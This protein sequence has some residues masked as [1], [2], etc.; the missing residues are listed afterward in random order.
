MKKLLFS[1]ALGAFCLVQADMTAQTLQKNNT[2]TS[3]TTKKVEK[4]DMVKKQSPKQDSESP[5]AKAKKMTDKLKSALM[6]NP[7]QEKKVHQIILDSEVKLLR[8]KGKEQ[9]KGQSKK[10]KQDRDVSIKQ[11]LSPTQK[12]KYDSIMGQHHT[13]GMTLHERATKKVERLDKMVKLT[14]EQKKKA[15]GIFVRHEMQR[16]SLHKN[17]VT[18]SPEV[19][20]KMQEINK[21]ERMAIRQILDPEQIQLWKAGRPGGMDKG[22]GR[23]KGQIDRGGTMNPTGQGRTKESQAGSDINKGKTVPTTKEGRID[24][25]GS[26]N[27]TGSTTKRTKTVPKKEASKTKKSTKEQKL[28]NPNTPSKATKSGKITKSNN[29]PSDLSNMDPVKRAKQ[30][31]DNMKRVLN[32]NDLRTKKISDLNLGTAQKIGKLL[33]SGKKE[34]TNKRQVSKLNNKRD[35]SI[36][37]LLTPEQITKFLQLNQKLEDRSN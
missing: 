4:G 19:N 1:F 32:L 36:K 5:A 20:A 16:E 11:L 35:A 14:D 8:L 18:D 28:E 27:S 3:K 2:P 21:S 29:L 22:E 37:K 6:L 13:Q 31:T 24:R 17:G 12:A 15:A 23:K 10:I 7:M 33:S 34:G 26:A 30:M 9:A 25:G